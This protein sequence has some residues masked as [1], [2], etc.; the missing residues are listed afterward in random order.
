MANQDECKHFTD[1]V[2]K[3]I[4]ICI[5]SPQEFFEQL[6]DAFVITHN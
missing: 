6:R 5:A 1:E 4:G 2:A 3:R